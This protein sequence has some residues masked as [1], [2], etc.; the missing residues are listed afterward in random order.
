MFTFRVWGLRGLGFR[1]ASFWSVLGFAITVLKGAKPLQ[2]ATLHIEVFIN[3]R[4]QDRNQH[5]ICR[6]L[7]TPKMRTAV[8]CSNVHIVLKENSMVDTE[9]R[10]SG[11]G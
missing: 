11:T 8:F 4:P 7:E 1:V 10:D 5:A 9:G 2:G 6:N 3:V